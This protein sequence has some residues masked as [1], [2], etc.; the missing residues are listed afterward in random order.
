MKFKALTFIIAILTALTTEAQMPADTTAQD[1]TNQQYELS[2]ITIEAPK[3]VRRAD[4]DVYYPSQSAVKASN[5]GVQVLKNLMIPT[6][7][8][9]DALS[10]I[11]SSGQEVEIRINGRKATVQELRNILPETIRRVEWLDNPGLRYNGAYAVLN[12]IVANPALGGSLMTSGMQSLNTAWGQYYASLKL[13]NGRSQWGLNTNFKLTNRMKAHRDYKEVFTYEDGSSLTRIETPL[14]GGYLSNTFAGLQLYYNYIKPDTTVLWVSMYGSKKWPEANKYNS[15]MTLSSGAD[16]IRLNEYTSNDGYNPMMSAYY[17]QHFA[18]DQIFVVDF[19]A[20]L[21]SG[22]SKHTYVEHNALTDMLITDVNTSVKDHNFAS[23][24]EANYIKKWGN[25]RLTAGLSYK[26]NRNRST[27]E[28]LGDAIFHQNQDRVYFYGEYFQ[29]IKKFTLTAGVGAQYTSFRLQE[30]AQETNSWNVRPSVTLMYNL[31]TASKFRV[32]FRTWQ[33]APSLTETNPAP[34][35]VDGFQVTIGNPMLKT[36]SSYDFGIRYNF[37]FPRFLGSFFIQ[38]FSSP[39]AIAPYSYWDNDKLITTYENSRGLQ[40]LKITLAPQ[41]EV[42]P[43]WLTVS[44]YIY[45]T[46]E[47]MRGTGYTHYNHNWAG[48]VSAH[49]EHWGFSLDVDYQKA[50]KSLFGEKITWGET[51]SAVMLSYNKNNWSFMA[52]MLFPFSKYEQGSRS[53]NKYNL[54][55]Y[56]MRLDISPI[57]LI[58]ITYNVQWGRQRR[59]AR[60][61]INAD[62]SADQTK[63]AGR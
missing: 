22:R 29:R 9:S 54:N 53:L 58:G 1:T 6:L 16:D 27:Y 36:S 51:L 4:M 30:T 17:E 61:L 14:P 37:N 19:D 49:A 11:T 38:G 46:A 57:P 2:E 59:D 33:T 3:L 39:N 28:N 7:S 26:A 56:K 20:E 48:S 13:N 8:V 42:I 55:E 23:A 62:G 40:N 60:K 44:G 63:T 10:K 21:Y 25:T 24:V 52:G 15:L 47:R 50:P 43:D 45:Y 34:Q 31:N 41:I 35:Q 12:F 32:W 18:H 5:N